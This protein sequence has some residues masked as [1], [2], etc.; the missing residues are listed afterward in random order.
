VEITLCALSFQGVGEFRQ[1][2]TA[3]DHSAV[4]FT[5]LG[6]GDIVMSEGH[7]I[8]GPLAAE[9]RI[10]IVAVEALPTLGFSARKVTFSFR[11]LWR[12]Q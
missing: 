1:S 9:H 3:F 7:R 5:T 6:Y 10:E 4:N 11:F 8:L 12:D 2:D